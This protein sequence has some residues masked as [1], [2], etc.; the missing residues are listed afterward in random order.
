LEAAQQGSETGEVL[1]PGE[2]VGEEAA[3]QE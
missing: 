1:S 3:P 2:E